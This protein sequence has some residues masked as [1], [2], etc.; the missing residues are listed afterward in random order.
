MNCC[1]ASWESR[2]A[3][4][5]KNG[6]AWAKSSQFVTNAVGVGL[7]SDSNNRTGWTVGTGLEWMFA[8]GWSVFGE[9]NY[10]NFGTRAVAV[11]VV[12]GV[13]AVFSTELTIQ[14][15]LVGVNYKFNWGGPVVGGY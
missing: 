4:E 2:L 10:M 3:S 6:G 7:E 14:Q 12:A 15:A 9:Y 11:P 8:P 5:E 13:A 1:A